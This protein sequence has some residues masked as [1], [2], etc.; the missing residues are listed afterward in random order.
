MRHRVAGRKL[1]RDT[2]HRLALYRNLTT[3]LLRYEKIVTTEA[4]AKEAKS[5]AEHVITLGKEGN[6]HARR[7]A[8]SL[9]TDK[10]VIKKVFDELAPRYGDRKGGYTRLVRL[11]PRVG[12]GASMAQLELV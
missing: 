10:K 1:S 7:R 12:D 4:K 2:G 8:L 11:G 6:L 3:D 5:L 9:V